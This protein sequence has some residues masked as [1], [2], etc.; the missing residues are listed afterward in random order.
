MIGS[1]KIITEE[2]LS[3]LRV[4]VGKNMTEK[5]YLHTLGVEKMASAISDLYC[6]ERKNILRAAALLHDITK[7]YDT[8]KHVAILEKYNVKFDPEEVLAPKTLHEKTAAVM[9]SQLYPE[10]TDKIIINAVRYHTTGRAFMSL[11]EK[12]VYL[13]D[14]ID[15]TRKFDDCVLLRGLFWD[16]CPEKMSLSERL[17]H[18]DRVM[19]ISFD[20]TIKGLIEE[21]QII[22][23]ET[24]EARNQL[25]VRL[26]ETTKGDFSDG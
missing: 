23:K 21:K 14:Y 8:E 4:K 25:I 12:I 17:T 5:R 15:E 22:N 26:K 16:A 18:L 7:A 13:S 9:I 20:M 1:N 6:P 2:M 10:F 11:E 19:L 24:T 3:D